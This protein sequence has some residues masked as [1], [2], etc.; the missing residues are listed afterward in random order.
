[1][2]WMPWIHCYLT[3]LNCGWAEL[4]LC[5]GDADLVSPKTQIKKL[6]LRSSAL[7]L[8][9][10]VDQMRKNLREIKT[11]GLGTGEDMSIETLM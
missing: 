11:A 8:A 9:A 7:A 5:D 6:C 3:A 10:H 1:M 4:R 2:L